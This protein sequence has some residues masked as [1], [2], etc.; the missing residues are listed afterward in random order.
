MKG[1]R[2]LL[3]RLEPLFARGG[4]FEKLGA[5]YE[6]MDTLLYSPPDITRSSPHV[7]DALDLKRV[8]FIVVVAATPAGLVGMWNTGFQAN[9][10]MAALGIEWATGWRG[11]MMALLGAGYEAASLYDNFVHGFLY[12]LPI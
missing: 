10:A 6:M 9:T 8:M 4:R 11:S 5:V 1:L 12:F 2:N 3:D 7:R